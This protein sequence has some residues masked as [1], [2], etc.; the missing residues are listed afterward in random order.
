MRRPMSHISS[1]SCERDFVLVL[2]VAMVL[3]MLL[4]ENKT[5]VMILAY[6]L[7]VGR[8]LSYDDYAAMD[9]R[10][11]QMNEPVRGDQ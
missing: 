5:S 2:T 3:S 1:L 6:F 10:I 9:V 4:R 11:M 7:G 8:I